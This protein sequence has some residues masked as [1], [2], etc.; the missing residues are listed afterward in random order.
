MINII[1]EKLTEIEDRT[2]FKIIIAEKIMKNIAAKMENLKKGDIRK[3]LEFL[4]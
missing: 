3:V 2:G 1:Q 4:K